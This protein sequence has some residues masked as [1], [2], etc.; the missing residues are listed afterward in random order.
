M[1]FVLC[2]RRP[3]KFPPPAQPVVNEDRKESV[4]VGVAWPR[5]NS[6]YCYLLLLEK[7]VC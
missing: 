3:K 7:C 2:Q 1:V 5:V 4:G 6:C